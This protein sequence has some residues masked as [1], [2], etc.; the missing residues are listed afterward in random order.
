MQ[1]IFF[2]I[3]LFYLAYVVV[4]LIGILHTIFNVKVLHMKS[5]K[6]SKGMGE[7]YE[8][9]KPWHPLYNLIIFPLFGYLYLKNIKFP[10]MEEAFTTGSIWF[11]LAIA[12]DYVGW[13]LIKHPW[14]LTY[15][16]FYVDYQPWLTIIYVLIFFGPIIAYW[17]IV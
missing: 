13:V 2:S 16:E 7:A 10:T 12:I 17:A 8:K 9:T 3:L 4:T 6:E 14:H 5:M 1:N 11:S 15:K